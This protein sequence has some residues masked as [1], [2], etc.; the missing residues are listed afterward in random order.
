MTPSYTDLTNRVAYLERKE[1][2]LQII[3]K[4]HDKMI[5]KLVL[6]K[7]KEEQAQ[8]ED[9][10]EE[11]EGEEQQRRRR[12]GRYLLAFTFFVILRNL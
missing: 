9:E 3:A 10:D 2:S 6:E 4:N 7:L 1:D 12:I 11:E 5:K 8:K